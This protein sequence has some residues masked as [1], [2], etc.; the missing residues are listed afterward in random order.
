L[1]MYIVVR[2]RSLIISISFKEARARFLIY[3]LT[4]R[5][6]QNIGTYLNNDSQMMAY[7]FGLLL[8]A[9]ERVIVSV[10]MDI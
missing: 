2:I 7:T 1:Y 9:K 5:V 6:L 8:F 10:S 4:G 3:R